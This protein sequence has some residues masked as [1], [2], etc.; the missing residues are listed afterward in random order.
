MVLDFRFKYLLPVFLLLVAI[1]SC[2]K[3]NCLN[4]GGDIVN[5]ERALEPFQY[6]ETYNSFQIYLQNDT[7]HKIRIEA[8]D[9]LI[10]FIE[11]KVDDGVLTIKDLNKC[12]F[13]KGYGQKKLYISVD[14][15]KEININEASDLHTVD[16]LKADRLKIRFLSQLGYCDLVV[17]TYD[18][19]LQI[20][21]ASGDFKVAGNTYYSYL[22]A[23]SSS[24]IYADSLTNIASTVNSNS[25][26]DCHFKAGSWANIEIKSSGNIYY[27]G[28][29][30]EIFIKEH[31]GSGK[32]IK[33]D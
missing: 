10:P 12:D 4:T 31:S 9:K 6:I 18:F 21:Y 3:N 23:E 30:G 26:G 1:H 28:K 24:F 7:I 33:K 17:D 25:M 8:G 16:T 27:S 15:I 29:P 32:L 2:K 11:T 14:T 19:R 13:I 5:V 20:W 22:S